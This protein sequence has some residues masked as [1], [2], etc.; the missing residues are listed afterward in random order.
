[1]KTNSAERNLIL[2]VLATMPEP[3]DF[4]QVWA[5]LPLVEGQRPGEHVVA[6][7]V[8]AERYAGRLV[9]VFNSTFVARRAIAAKYRRVD[10]ERVRKQAAAASELTPVEKMWREWGL[11]VFGRP[12]PQEEAAI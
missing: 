6:R 7:V 11:G 5:A 1:M 10:Q 9:R 8:H 4:H 3:F 2:Q 12:A